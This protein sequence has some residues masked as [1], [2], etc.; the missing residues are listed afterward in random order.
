MF[1]KIDIR[2]KLIFILLLLF[3]FLVIIKVFYIQ[4]FDYKKLNILANNLWSRELEIEA[5]RGKI[6]DRNGIVLA[7]NLTTSSLVLI[8]SQIKDKELTSK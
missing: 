8:P 3:F 6:F 2:I 1:K 5:D 4:V 7:D